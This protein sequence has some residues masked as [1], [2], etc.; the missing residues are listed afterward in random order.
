MARQGNYV[1]IPGMDPNWAK[2]ISSALSD[3]SNSYNRKAAL[4]EQ[5]KRLAANEAENKRRYEEGLLRQDQRN[6]LL[7]ERYKNEQALAAEKYQNTLDR[8]GELDRIAADER[9]RAAKEREVLS[10]Y[11]ANYSA[12]SARQAMLD[13]DPEL[14]SALE[15]QNATNKE[16]LASNAIIDATMSGEQ[17]RMLREQA[18]EF[19]PSLGLTA[20]AIVPEDATGALEKAIAE[21]KTSNMLDTFSADSSALEDRV[22]EYIRS[23]APLYREQ[24]QARINKELIAEGADPIRAAA[25]AKELSGQ[26]KSEEDLTTQAIARQKAQQTSAEK[27]A[28]LVYK[29]LKFEQDQITSSGNKNPNYI[30]PGIVTDT[31][32]QNLIENIDPGI[33]DAGTLR[34]LYDAAVAAG[35]DQKVALKSL[36]ENIEDNTT[37]GVRTKGPKLGTEDF[38][39]YAKAREAS[40]SPTKIDTSK[41]SRDEFIKLITPETVP[42]VDPETSNRE[43]FVRGVSRYRPKVT[44]L[45]LVPF[46]PD[47]DNRVSSSVEPSTPA[48]AAVSVPNNLDVPNIERRYGSASSSSIN[49]EARAELDAALEM[50]RLRRLDEERAALRAAEAEKPAGNLYEGVS[51]PNMYNAVAEELSPL[52]N[53][54]LDPSAYLNQYTNLVDS[55]RGVSLEDRTMEYLNN[56]STEY[57][58][59][60]AKKPNLTAMERKLIPVILESRNR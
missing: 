25:L 10:Q 48:P 37:L 52:R 14:K 45:P 5:E 51:L 2:G 3:L 40:N 38:I 58:L 23:N 60:M 35:V 33:K 22:N 32:V 28:D 1:T 56:R 15:A 27:A 9:A 16:V 30:K 55:L 26:Y 7:D 31:Q 39:A 4:E 54:I 24:E 43:A 34:D 47:V 49:P 21:G 20:D 12:P 19:G 17:G 29:A 41:I 42:Y 44:R 18:A 36:E 57:L 59:D 50:A 8:Q 11:A 46:G 13:A 6:A 53:T